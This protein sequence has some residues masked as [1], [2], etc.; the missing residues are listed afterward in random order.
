M[1][2]VAANG[3][4]QPDELVYFDGAWLLFKPRNFTPPELP[5]F[6]SSDAAIDASARQMQR[7]LLWSMRIAPKPGPLCMVT[8]I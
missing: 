2:A 4:Q 3:E 5:P 8:G 6:E 7:D 1:M